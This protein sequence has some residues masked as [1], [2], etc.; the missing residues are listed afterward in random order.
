MPYDLSYTSADRGVQL[1]TQPYS[2]PYMPQKLWYGLNVCQC[3]IEDSPL[4]DYVGEIE[5]PIFYISS[6]GATGEHGFY[7]VDLLKSLDVTKYIV[8]LNSEPTL[9]F[10]HGDLFIA[11]N[12]SAEV[13]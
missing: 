2:G 7:S 5:V 11:N 13:W 6:G 3:N 9:N 8:S 4:D 12:S 10:G 1:L